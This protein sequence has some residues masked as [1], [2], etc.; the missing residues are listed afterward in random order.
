[1]IRAEHWLWIPLSVL[2][3]WN[4]RAQTDAA[5]AIVLS[6]IWIA[7]SITNRIAMGPHAGRKV[8]TLQ[9]I[10]AREEEEYGTEQLGRSV[11]GCMGKYRAA[12]WLLTCHQ[13]RLLVWQIAGDK[14]LMFPILRSKC[15]WRRQWWCSSEHMV[16][17]GLQLAVVISPSN[18]P[19]IRCKISLP[20]N[21]CRSDIYRLLLVNHSWVKWR[22]ITLGTL[23]IGKQAMRTCT[24]FC[25]V[26]FGD[27]NQLPQG[28]F[29]LV[30]VHRLAIIQPVVYVL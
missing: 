28:R 26:Y 25:V 4:T 18:Y 9:T 16:W 21:N 11:K 30:P 15:S 23:Q 24:A 1:M 17:D 5:W 22:L 10:P 27:I 20:I 8:L 6:W 2:G 29:L 13:Y 7:C 14:C 3:C 12:E 19:K